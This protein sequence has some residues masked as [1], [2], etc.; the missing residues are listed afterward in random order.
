MVTLTYEYGD[1]WKPNA[2][3][4]FVKRC[5]KEL[6]DKLL[7][8]TWVAEMQQ[9]GVIHYHVLLLVQRGA[10]I[11]KPDDAG[12]WN[13][14]STRIET[15]RSAFYICT[16]VGKEYQ[17][18]GV[19]PKGARV[20]GSYVRKGLLSS[21]EEHDYK[22]DKVPKWVAG[23][24]L[25]LRGL[26][27]VGAGD[28]P[29]RKRGRWCVGWLALRSPWRVEGFSSA[30]GAEPKA[31]R[32]RIVAGQPAIQDHWYFADGFEVGQDSVKKAAEI[33]EAWRKTLH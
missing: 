16:Y 22:L 32:V 31:E 21:S 26:D 12:W 11:E 15:A 30:R 17:K 7:A 27:M 2:I 19:F 5:Q 28:V 6:R 29:V 13:F 18:N 3:N 1:D 25:H 33:F 14:G 10:R 9:R 24:Y 4:G 23:E 8:Y 20:C